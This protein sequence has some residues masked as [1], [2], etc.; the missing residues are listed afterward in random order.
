MSVTMR[1]RHWYAIFVASGQEDHVKIHINRGLSEDYEFRMVVPKR[2]IRERKS[3]EWRDVIRTMFPGYILIE[4]DMTMELH[5]KIRQTTGVIKILENEGEPTPIEPGEIE[6]INRLTQNDE[7]IGFSKA[8]MEDDKVTITDGPLVGQ[9]GLI[10]SIN[11]R[12]G[13]AKVKISL[14]GEI[15]TVDLG[16]EVIMPSDTEV[17]KPGEMAFATD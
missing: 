1:E 12:K 11:R 17:H 6:I 9:E 5:A 3:G 14:F 15:R 4:A 10:E 2:L 8:L 16:M 7:I 13:R